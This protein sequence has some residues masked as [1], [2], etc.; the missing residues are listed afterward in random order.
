MYGAEASL[1]LANGRPRG[2]VARLRVPYR[3]L[4]LDTEPAES[5]H[6]HG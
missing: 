1:T 6:E 5:A 4:A 2:T 3:E